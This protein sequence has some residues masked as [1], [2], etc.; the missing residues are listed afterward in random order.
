[1][2]LSTRVLCYRVGSPAFDPWC[3]HALQLSSGQKEKAKRKSKV[4]QESALNH[5][6]GILDCSY[7]G[8]VLGLL[9]SLGGA[10]AVTVTSCAAFHPVSF[11]SPA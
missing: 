11:C 9:R 3:P 1:M 5:V 6:K 4:N 8:Q 10:S 2:Q 7:S